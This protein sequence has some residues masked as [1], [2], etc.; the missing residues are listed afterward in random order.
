MDKLLLSIWPL[1]GIKRKDAVCR[2][3]EMIII[4]EKTPRYNKEWKSEQEIRVKK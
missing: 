2:L 1:D 4:T 3:A